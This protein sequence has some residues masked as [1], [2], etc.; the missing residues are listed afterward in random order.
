MS[1]QEQHFSTMFLGKNAWINYEYLEA[2]LASVGNGA[3][4]ILVKI[5]RA[6]FIWLSFS[7]YFR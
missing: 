4:L 6:V 1:R 2:V 3:Y 7:Q 5:D